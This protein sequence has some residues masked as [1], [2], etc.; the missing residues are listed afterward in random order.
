MM[1]RTEFIIG[2]AAM[3]TCM[4]KRIDRFLSIHGISF[5]EFQVLHHLSNAPDKTLRRIDL[6]EQICMSA[7][8]VTR[9]LNPME[10]LRL[11]QKEQNAR[12][13][14]VSLIKLAKGGERVYEMAR[15]SFEEGADIVLKPLND[16]QLT[17]LSELVNLLFPGQQ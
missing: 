9:L 13:A 5:S 15:R 4:V 7:S 6:A 11:V 10:K 3:Q 2:F 14:R 1:D 8:G 16:S 12:D 17:K